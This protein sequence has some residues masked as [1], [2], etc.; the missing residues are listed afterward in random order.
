[1]PLSRSTRVTSFFSLQSHGQ[2]VAVTWQDATCTLD[3]CR[4][5]RQASFVTRRRFRRKP[6]ENR[7]RLGSLINRQLEA[8]RLF[9]AVKI[10][11]AF[12]GEKN[13]CICLM[14]A[15]VKCHGEERG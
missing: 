1:M 7:A 8:P 11:C 14:A 15:G 6:V 9:A 12:G 10:C 13:R 4:R 5:R 2:P 3:L